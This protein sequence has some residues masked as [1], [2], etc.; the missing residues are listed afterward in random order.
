MA[1]YGVFG[2]KRQARANIVSRVGNT[3][4]M[5]V[6]HK[7]R[8]VIGDWFAKYLLAQTINAAMLAN[9]I[10]IEHHAFMVDTNAF[11]AANASNIKGLV[12][13]V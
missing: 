3:V 10:E 2:A 11:A 8:N 4:K 12:D 1:H 7:A 9:A 5:L 13:F 6:V